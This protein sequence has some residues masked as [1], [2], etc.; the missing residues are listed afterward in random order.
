M[1]LRIEKGVLFYQKGEVIRK[2]GL[3][4]L[5]TLLI[6]QP[7]HFSMVKVL[8]YYREMYAAMFAVLLCIELLSKRKSLLSMRH[9]V[10]FL[11]LFLFVLIVAAL[12]DPCIPLYGAVNN[13]ASEHLTSI[14]PRIYIL[15][16][17]IIYLPVLFYLSVRGF[18]KHD[19]KVVMMACALMAPISILHFLSSLKLADVLMVIELG[20]AGLQYNSYAPYLTYPFAA[21]LCLFFVLKNKIIKYAFGLNCVFIFLYLIITTSRQSV[22]FAVICLIG[23]SIFVSSKYRAR[24]L[25]V[26]GIIAVAGAFLVP[27]FLANYNV[28]A[29]IL[30]KFGSTEAFET[31][32]FSIMRT[33]LNVMNPI[34]YVTGAGLSSVVTSGPHN[35]YIRWTQRIGVFGMIIGFSPFLLAFIKALKLSSKKSS[36]YMIF[37]VVAIFYTLYHSLFG[38]PREDAYQSLYCFLGLASWLACTQPS[39]AEDR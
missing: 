7:L 37:L 28:D 8:V 26:M 35:D 32:R 31:S 10:F 18:S 1:M 15:R 29:V 3:F 24:F 5:C 6:M 12:V 39:F 14:D 38:Y 25:L 13:Q 21:S 20:G 17:A 27:L 36:P 19:L 16:N 9:E 2:A 34:D 11:L 23:F 33:G 4:L 30:S 22:L